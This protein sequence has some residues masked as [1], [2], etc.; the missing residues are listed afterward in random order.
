MKKILRIATRKSPMALWQAEHVQKLLQTQHP[1]IS[2]EL[3]PMSTTGDTFLENSLANIG[4]KGLFLKELETALLSGDA[5]IAVHSAKDVPADL[6][7][8][9]TLAAYLKRDD[10]R[11]AFV[12]NHYADLKM[13]PEGARIGTSSHRRHCLLKHTRPDLQVV[14]LRGN[15]QTRL[16]KLDADEFDGIILSAA[17]LIR[18]DLSPRI[19]AYLQTDHFIPAVGQG[20]I[21]IECRQDDRAT[22]HLLAALNDPGTDLC[23]SAE[24]ALSQHLNGGCHAPLGGYAVIKKGGV[25][26]L[27]AFVGGA[28]GQ[29]MLYAEQQGTN[30]ETLGVD[31]AE[32]LLALG[33]KRFL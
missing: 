17:G 18:L 24:R 13:L 30:P 29:T 31:V 2:I 19:R 26:H 22:Q 27:L 25:L 32:K 15:V 28:D 3:L 6:N 14:L 21:C 7:E 8:A 1:E 4:G 10:P 5:D 9:F 12:S 11:D 20:V 33:A 23:V 16:R